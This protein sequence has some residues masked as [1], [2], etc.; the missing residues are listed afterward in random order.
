MIEYEFSFVSLSSS[1]RDEDLNSEFDKF[2]S[3]EEMAPCYRNIAS[4]PLEL[5]E[6]PKVYMPIW[7]RKSETSYRMIYG[8]IL[9]IIYNGQSAAKYKLERKSPMV[10]FNLPIEPHDYIVIGRQENW[11]YITK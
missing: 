9:R 6:H 11:T 4:K 10:N 8:E 7:R 1:R 2:E 5:L 3:I